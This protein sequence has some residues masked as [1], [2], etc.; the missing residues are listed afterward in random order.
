MKY[1]NV[2]YLEGR[3]LSISSPTYFIA[4]IAS[5]H[6]GDLE[7]A[8]DLIFLAKEAGAEAAKFQHFLARHIVSDRGFRSLGGNLG[9]QARWS[10][11]V[12]EIYRQYECPRDWTETLAETCTRADIHFLTSPY[13]MEAIDAFAQIIPAYKIGSGD[14]TWPEVLLRIASKGKP[15]L[16]ATGAS[17]MGEVER[18]VS[19]IISRNRQLVLMQCNTN[20]TGSLENFRFVNLRVLQSFALR[21]PQML[22]GL[23]DHT[24]GHA[25]VLGAVTLGARVVEK[26]FTDDTTRSGPDHAFSLTPKTW[27]EMVDRTRELEYALGDGVKRVED[28]EQETVVLQR[29]CLRFTRD[30]AAGAVIRADDLEPL[31]PAPLGSVPPSDLAQVVGSELVSD[32]VAGDALFYADVRRQ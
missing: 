17:D 24:P 23:S 4:D 11:S 31:R 6:D 5:N 12:Y 2:I 28:N 27:R 9:H 10:K 3:E 32:K 22:L 16:L 30:L 15:V 13:D 19:T 21:W 8:K 18:A 14:I 7:R 29:R 1:D 20:Y 26:H 25:A